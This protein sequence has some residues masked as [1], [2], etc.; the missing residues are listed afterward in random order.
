M[1]RSMEPTYSFSLVFW[2]AFIASNLY[3][4][5]Q[6][7]ILRDYRSLF[8]LYHISF[9]NVDIGFLNVVSIISIFGYP[10]CL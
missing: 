3:N 5:I 10:L 4:E 9:G 8:L 1:I 6:D 2:K 7:I